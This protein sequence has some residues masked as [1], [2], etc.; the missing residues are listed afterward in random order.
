VDGLDQ[1]R[2]ERRTVS[3]A[4]AAELRDRLAAGAASADS[5]A[6]RRALELGAEADDGALAVALV[7]AVAS[8]SVPTLAE[9]AATADRGSQDPSRILRGR[10]SYLVRL[11]TGVSEPSLDLQQLGDARTLLAVCRAGTLF[12]RRAALLRL[13]E[14]IDSPQQLSADQLAR[15]VEAL[16]QL[17]RFDVAYE[18][19]RVCAA[20]PG[21]AGRDARAQRKAWDGL[22]L[23]VM[24]DLAAYWD[25][26]RNAE[27]LA[28]LRGEER[29]LLLARCRDLPDAALGHIT[30]ILENAAASGG[31]GE[32][33]A[34]LAAL[35]NSGDR[36]LLPTLCS[37]LNPPAA[38]LVAPA[39]RGLC[40]IEDPR[41]HPLL[42]A[43][44]ERA[45][46][47]EQRLALAGALGTLGDTRGLPYVRS[48][49]EGDVEALKPLALDALADL[50]TGDDAQALALDK[51]SGAAL[52]KGIRVLEQVGDGRALE[53]LGRLELNGAR[54]ALQ[55]D[56]EDAAA[57]IRARL[58]LLGEEAPP[59]QAAAAAFDTAKMAVLRRRQDPAT[60]RM[61][62]RWS[63]WLAQIWAFVGS[64]GRAVARF[65]TAA[66]L[67]PEWV[68]PVI[69]L[70]LLYARA[71][72]HTQTLASFRRALD[73][74][75]PAVE[76]HTA[77]V[78]ALA[79]AFLRR[80]EAVERDGRYD[81]AFGLLE[82]AL[83]LDLRRVPSGLRMALSQRHEALRAREA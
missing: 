19:S 60:V 80:S 73:I 35:Q 64:R 39:A 10:T 74:E 13:G 58:E 51:L 40:R 67:R 46:I 69:S 22:V 47:A 3:G 23:R 63:L 49:L 2:R 37:L 44:Y 76:G 14:L 65:E 50:G 16:P 42:K 17:R 71:E 29:V 78:C 11:G 56:I 43:C 79:Q 62:A 24:Q 7:R 57:A 66:A 38:E 72:N 82:E 68:T 20:L 55:A 36:R 54:S 18:L 21:A 83:A 81:I 27:P 41:V 5:E 1:Q 53:S 34:L 25:G 70:S 31:P 32:R 6:L 8:S 77:A 26:E 4:G 45:V 33:A 15:V 12:Q 75:R 48:V 28:E 61:R 30:A 52:K 9:R 59:A